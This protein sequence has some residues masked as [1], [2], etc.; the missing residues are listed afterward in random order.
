MISRILFLRWSAGA[1]IALGASVGG[2]LWNARHTDR[3]P[4]DESAT[5][6]AAA[7]PAVDV[8][9]P[10]A[11]EPAAVDRRLPMSIPD[12]PVIDQH[13]RP[14]R[15]HSDL[16]KGRVVAINFLFTTCRTICP[17]Q[18]IVFGQLQRPTGERPVHLI[19]VS[20]DPVNDRP[21]QLDAWA[22]RYGTGPN[23]TLVTG[24]KRDIDGLLKSLSAFTPDKNSH[25]AFTLIGDDRTGTWRRLSGIAPADSIKEAIEAVARAGDASPGPAASAADKD[26]PARRYFTDV[27][28]VNQ[29]GETMRLYSDVLRGKV[30]VIH[31]FFSGCSQTCPVLLATCQRLQDHLG[32]RLGRDVHLISI[33]VDPENDRWESLRDHAR[34]LKARRGW[35]LLTGSSQDVGLALR[36]LGQAVDRREDHSNIFFIG[37]ERTGLWKKVQGLAPAEQII[38]ILDGVIADKGTSSLAESAS[39]Q[40]QQSER[41]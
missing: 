16:I 24:E 7:E 2:I 23:W 38:D 8:S 34:R 15:F 3:T 40:P 26:T 19:S 29:H 41:P 28:L 6:C 37:N 4:G 39:P 31:V 27:P 22:K 17:T 10:A 9:A 35:Y 20:L 11:A 21:E 36:K 32:D 33:T 5:C 12:T 13:G 25:S 18:S 30:V 1:A 14:R